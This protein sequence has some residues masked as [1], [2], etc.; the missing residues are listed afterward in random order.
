M[1]AEVRNLA[2]L[3][4]RLSTGRSG[5]DIMEDFSPYCKTPTATTSYD[6]C[7]YEAPCAVGLKGIRFFGT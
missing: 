1:N 2:G 7:C 5:W 4:R 6:R 3:A